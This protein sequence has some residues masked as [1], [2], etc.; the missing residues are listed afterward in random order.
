MRMEYL[1]KELELFEKAKN[2]KLYFSSN[3]KPY[4]SGEVIEVGAGIGGTI[5]F[6]INDNVTSWLCYEPDKNLF[7]RLRRKNWKSRSI[8]IIF[9][10]D[11]LER[12]SK[13][14]DTILYI[15]VLE[16]IE[17]DKEEVKMAFSKLR[18]GGH[19]IILVPAFNYLF[20]EFDKSIGHFRRYDKGMIK[21]LLPEK[22]SLLILKY[23]DS[24]GFLSSVANKLFLKQTYP[25]PAQI[26]FWDNILI[27]ISKVVDPVFLNSFGKTLIVVIKK[28]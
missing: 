14:A 7:E 9:K 13:M 8:P 1:G 2:W 4:I 22:S 27:P 28:V 19:L 17:K 20:N 21:E 3:I 6:L 24:L 23:L 10:N 26:K 25:K 12:S 16:H 5:Q 11:V 15:D 18:N